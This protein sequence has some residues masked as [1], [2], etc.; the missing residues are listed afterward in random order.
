MTGDKVFV[1]T[2]VLIYAYNISAGGKHE[3][4]VKIMDELWRSGQGSLS[5]QVLQEFFVVVTKKIPC[6]LDIKSAKDIIKDMLKWDVV[7]NNGECILE[8]INIHKR[9][10]YSFWDSMII[11]AAIRADAGLLLSE[12][13]SDSQVIEGVKIKNP[14]T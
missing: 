6:P 7:I 12:D 5:T 4:A 1:D 8:A 10:K 9:Y 13:L 11:G 14:F 2:N 3:A